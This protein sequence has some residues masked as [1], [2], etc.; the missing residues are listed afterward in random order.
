MPKAAPIA[1]AIAFLLS[2]A[3]AVADEMPPEPWHPPAKGVVQDARAAITIAHA[4]WLSMNPDTDSTTGNEAAWQS[5]MKATLNKGAWE[6]MQKDEQ[7]L[8][9]RIAQRDGR[10]VEIYVIK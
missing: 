5:M 2:A 6:V 10:I 3:V 4:V 8:V 9:F 7:G 1:V